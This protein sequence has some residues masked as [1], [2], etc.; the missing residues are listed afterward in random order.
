VAAWEKRTSATFIDFLEALTA[1][2]GTSVYTP[3]ADLPAA[4]Q[5]VLLQGSGAESITYVFERGST[6]VRYQRPFEGII[7]NL[8]RR[9]ARRIPMR[10]ARTSS[11]S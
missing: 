6:R 2:Y 11:V 4:F 3:F 8:E 1:H 10:S 5:R 9:Y 7:P